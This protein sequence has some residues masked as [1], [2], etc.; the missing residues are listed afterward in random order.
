MSDSDELLALARELDEHFSGFAQSFVDYRD[1]SEAWREE[2]L[3]E[4]ARRYLEGYND[5]HRRLRLLVGETSILKLPGPEHKRE[6]WFLQ[7]VLVG[8]SPLDRLLLKMDVQNPLHFTEDELEPIVDEYLS[9]FSYLEY[10]QAKVAGAVLVVNAGELPP[11]LMHF[12]HEIQECFAFKRYTAVYAL[13]RTALEA[14]LLP[15]YRVNRLDHPDSRNSQYVRGKIN[16]TRMSPKKKKRLTAYDQL[17]SHLTL[18]DFSPTL[19]QMIT[20]LCW[21]PN[22]SGARVGEEWLRNVLHSIRDRG[23][24]LIHANTTADRA[25]ARQ[26]MNDLFQALH[27]L[28]E[29]DVHTEER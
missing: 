23:N 4:E 15:L 9:W 3:L 25:S 24:S 11:D 17:Y 14:G 6:R 12:V 1:P 27:A 21:L 7:Q 29:I 2:E 20:R 22:Y 18:D 8:E 28:Y 16:G 5:A 26:M 19:E 13:C 10:A